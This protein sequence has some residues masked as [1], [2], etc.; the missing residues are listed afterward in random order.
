MFRGKKYWK[1]AGVFCWGVCEGGEP[2][3]LGR[4]KGRASF[5]DEWEEAHMKQAVSDESEVGKAPVMWEL[6]N[7]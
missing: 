6:L 2:S 3:F 5:A 1:H 7:I 4:A